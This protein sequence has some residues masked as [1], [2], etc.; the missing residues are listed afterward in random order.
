MSND[1]V[2]VE[3]GIVGTSIEHH[4]ARPNAGVTL[5]RRAGPVRG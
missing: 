3:A 1:L 2:V 4:A 5:V